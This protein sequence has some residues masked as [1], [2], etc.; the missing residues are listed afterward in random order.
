MGDVTRLLARARLGDS[1]ASAQLV[2]AVYRELRAIAGRL[3]RG[4]R[5]GHTM[6]ATELV[7]EAW[8]R[9]AGQQDVEVQSRAHFF[10]LAARMMR[11]VLVDYARRHHAVKRGGGGLRETLDEGMVVAEDRLADM[12][13]VDE[14]L[15][16]LEA[17]DARQARIVELRF[18]AG[19]GM[20]EIAGILGVSEPTVKRE[21]RSARAW[22]ASQMGRNNDGGTL[23]GNK[24]DL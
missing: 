2:E 22:L 20:E 4:E 11:Q 7:H 12:L 24:A 16:R 23:A 18:F 3:L 5:S 6:Q 15:Q 14:A 9:L 10:N 21:W 13:T 17:I 19:L 1:A 8:L